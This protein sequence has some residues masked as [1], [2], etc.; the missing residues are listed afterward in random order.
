MLGD[1]RTAR[2]HQEYLDGQH[3][4]RDRT[5]RDTLARAAH[6]V[7]MRLVVRT[8]TWHHL[9]TRPHLTDVLAGID[10]SRIDGDPEDLRATVTV[11]LSGP[12][13]V[14]LA[15]GLFADTET[16]DSAPAEQAARAMAGRLYPTLAAA[17]GTLYPRPLMGA[18]PATAGEVRTFALDSPSLD[19][20]QR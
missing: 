12:Q 11:S 3:R 13:L 8:D 17:I 10:A 2:R 1:K 19:S 15:A 5:M 14:H 20:S 7:G 16:D 4:D 6:L 18:A 9:G